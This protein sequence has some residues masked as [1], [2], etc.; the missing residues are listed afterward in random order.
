MTWK[1]SSVGWSVCWCTTSFEVFKFGIFKMTTRNAGLEGFRT[2]IKGSRGWSHS[3]NVPPNDLFL[4]V[5]SS[6]SCRS[7]EL[8]KY[9][10]SESSNCKTWEASHWKS[11]GSLRDINE[12]FWVDKTSLSAKMLLFRLS[13]FQER[14]V[15]DLTSV[16]SVACT[17]LS[18][19]ASL[20]VLHH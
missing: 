16:A 18:E 11:C 6:G 8:R 4:I 3:S 1:Y 5:G 12:N 15:K 20:N 9:L 13:Q 19:A 2:F 7:S 17:E 14:E 10:Y